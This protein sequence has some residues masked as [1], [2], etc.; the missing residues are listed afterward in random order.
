MSVDQARFHFCARYTHMT[1]TAYFWYQMNKSLRQDN[2]LKT[3]A[4]NEE[5]MSPQ[6][7]YFGPE[8]HFGVDPP[9]LCQ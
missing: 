4:S 7:K 5:E 8:F 9:A 3:I 1:G 2:T 6:E